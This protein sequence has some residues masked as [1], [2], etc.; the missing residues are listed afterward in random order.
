MEI[1]TLQKELLEALEES[2]QD[3]SSSLWLVHLGDRVEVLS[4]KVYELSNCIASIDTLH[5]VLIPE[6]EVREN[7]EAQEGLGSMENLYQAPRRND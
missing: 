2:S 5:E 6:A 4:D 1:A 7:L 3:L